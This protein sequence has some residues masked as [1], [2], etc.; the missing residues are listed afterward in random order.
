MYDARHPDRL[1]AAESLSDRPLLDAVAPAPEIL[2]KVGEAFATSL[3][4]L[5]AE[6]ARLEASGGPSK[7]AIAAGRARLERLES[8][9]VLIQEIGRITGGHAPLP[10][11]R[12]DLA[13]AARAAVAEHMARAANAGRR[14]V[15]G[16]AAS[17]P[18]LVNAATLARLVDLAIE[19]A[20]T[21]GDRVVVDATWSDGADRHPV[22]AIAVVR[23]DPRAG[24]PGAGLPWLLFEYLSVALGWAPRLRAE[25]PN[26][27][28]SLHLP[29][30]LPEHAAAAVTAARTPPVAGRQALLLEP[31]EWHRLEALRLLENAGVVVHPAAS[32][33]QARLLIGEHP[34]DVV[35]TGVPSNDPACSA[36]LADA[37]AAQPRLRVLEL[38]D[39]GD[40]FDFSAPGT[41]HPARVSRQALGRTLLP[42]LSQEIDSAW[43][44]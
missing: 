34:P 24:E 26:V 39:D 44:A 41:G 15:A 18:V 20:C 35:V 37:R 16:G 23:K 9:G 27:T 38:V 12:I 8:L 33:A 14:I 6:L 19:H 10:L 1:A 43:S 11:E 42:A 5:L 25:G 17:L 32:V 2:V 13:A 22:L 28:L 29:S 7:A 3:A 21:L 40:A 36:L 30:E 31:H 4:A